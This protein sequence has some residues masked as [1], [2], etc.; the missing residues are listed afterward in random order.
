MR[1]RKYIA[2]AAVLVLAGGGFAAWTAIGPATARDTGAAP[3]T[4]VIILDPYL[5]GEI[6]APPGDAAPKLTA[7]QAV[8]A[9]TGKKH[10]KIPG[11]V[12]IQLGLFTL[13]IGDAS[14]CNR[15]DRCP[16]IA[17][18]IAYTWLRK[19]VYGFSSRVCPARSHKPAWRCTRWDFIDANSGKYIAG[20]I[21]RV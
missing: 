5:K 2:G 12:T 18:G 20:L 7:H 19:L 1:P 8:A 16:I 3:V 21:P 4:S 13:P 9:W 11:D 14:A 10:F 15:H 6:L 17:H